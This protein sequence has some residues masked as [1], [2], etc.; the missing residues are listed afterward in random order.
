[1]C[2]PSMH[3]LDFRPGTRETVGTHTYPSIFSYAP[4]LRYCTT[5]RFLTREKKMQDQSNVIR[6]SD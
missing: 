5:T 4:T 1:M 3:E 6:Y 2:L